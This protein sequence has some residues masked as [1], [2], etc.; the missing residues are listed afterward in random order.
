MKLIDIGVNLTNAAFD[1]DQADVLARAAQAGVDTLIITGTSLASSQQALEL[2]TGHDNTSLL[3]CTAGIHPHDAKDASASAIAELSSLA[4]S[5]RV[6]AVGETGLDFNRD[7]SPRPLQESAFHAQLEIAARVQKPVFL[8]E[9]DAFER[10]LAILKEHRDDIPGGV[11][12]CF[13]GTRQALYAYLDLGLAIGITGWVCDERRGQELQQLIKDIPLD[14]LLLETDAPYLVPRT[15]RPKP[16]S[17]R[18]EPAFLPEVLQQVARLRSEPI[19]EI[20]IRT[21]ANAQRLFRLS[22]MQ[23]D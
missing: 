2:C 5:D 11:Q 10:Q 23:K 4:K 13:T 7:F 20:A 8:H 22:V 9:R 16:K 21:T 18:N 14:Q 3:Y 6:V 15:L 17:G 19:E 1:R 12:H